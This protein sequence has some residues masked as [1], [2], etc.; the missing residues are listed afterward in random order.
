[1]TAPC[2]GDGAD[3]GEGDVLGAEQAMADAGEPRGAERRGCAG[4]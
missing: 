4:A 1:M 2:D 3:G